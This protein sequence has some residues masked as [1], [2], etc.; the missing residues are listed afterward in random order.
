M[1][2]FGRK[3]EKEII[4]DLFTSTLQHP[5][6]FATVGA[7]MSVKTEPEEWVWVE[8]FKG[9]DKDMKC[10]DYQFE[11]NKQASM[12]EGAEIRECQS[13]FHLCLKLKDV[14]GYYDLCNGNRFFKVRALVRAKDVGLSHEKLM[15]MSTSLFES[16]KAKLTSKSIIFLEEIGIDDIFDTYVQRDLNCSECAGWTAED[17]E[18]ARQKNIRFVRDMHLVA[19]L[20]AF[21]FSEAFAEYAVANDYYHYAKAAGSQEGLSMDMKVLTMFKFKE[22]HDG[23][24]RMAMERSSYVTTCDY[25]APTRSGR[26]W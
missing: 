18:L 24:Y 5:L 1:S 22:D 15:S 14:F 6:G 26:R 10:R 4:D 9:T 19:E 25:S 11:L 2:I 23:Q 13:G 7:K 17:K 12:P 3:T 16:N 21:G 8:G 20:K